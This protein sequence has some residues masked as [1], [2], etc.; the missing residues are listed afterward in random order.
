MTSIE[1][2]KTLHAVKVYL[3]LKPLIQVSYS[4]MSLCCRNEWRLLWS[5]PVNKKLRN[6]DKHKKFRCSSPTCLCCSVASLVSRN[7]QSQG[8]ELETV[9][10]RRQKMACLTRAARVIRRCTL[11]AMHAVH[12]RCAWRDGAFPRS[13]LHGAERSRPPSGG[14]PTLAAAV[15]FHHAFT[16]SF[17]FF[18][19]GTR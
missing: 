16:L 11:H 10:K 4:A 13:R 15:Y 1:I 7:C 6:A 12:M 5:R 19:R 14:E 3:K 18:W 8:S 17:F 2:G 9:C